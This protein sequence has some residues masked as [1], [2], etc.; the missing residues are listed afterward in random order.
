L[1]YRLGVRSLIAIAVLAALSAVL[2]L[3]SV[4]AGGSGRAEA[5][6]LLRLDGVQFRPE[7]AITPETR[8]TGLM[9]RRKAPADG[10]LFVFRNDTTGA[11]WMRNTLVPLR[12]VFFSSQGKRVRQLQ[13]TPCRTES[14]PLYSPG[15]RYR[16]A[17]ELRATDKRPAATLGPL[18]RLQQL[19]RR[20]S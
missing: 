19:S 14:C 8:G 2:T 5:T 11:F 13:M 12:I 10:M 18:A 20:A 17:L 6:A 16:Y 1:A 7:L 9:H 3:S 4:A 15:R